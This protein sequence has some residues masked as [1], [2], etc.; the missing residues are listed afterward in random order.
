MKKDSPNIISI[1]VNGFPNF[2]LNTLVT[3]A[4]VIHIDISNSIRK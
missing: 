4:D 3:V 1:I 2:S